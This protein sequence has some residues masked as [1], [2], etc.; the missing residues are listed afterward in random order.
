MT[1]NAHTTTRR[2]HRGGTPLVERSVGGTRALAAS[3]YEATSCPRRLRATSVAPFVA[4][5]DPG[6]R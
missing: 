6:K 2:Q 4:F 5:D 3:R 1:W